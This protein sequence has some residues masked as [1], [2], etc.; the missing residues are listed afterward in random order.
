M[1]GV[2]LHVPF[3]RTLCPYCDFVKRPLE[4]AVPEAFV[5]AIEAEIQRFE[6]PNEIVSIFFGG[7]TPSLL[8]RDALKRIIDAIGRRFRNATGIDELEITLEANPDDV[9]LDLAEMW[10]D[11]GVNRVSLGV[12]SFNDEVL[13][14]LG[15]RHD[16]ECAKKACETVA[17]RFENW[18]MDFI[19]GARPLEPWPDTLRECR[20]FGSPH[21]STYALSYEDKTPFYKRRNDAIDDDAYVACVEAA[22][23]ALDHVSRYEI[24]NYAKPGYESR[25]NLIYWRNESYAGFG[26]G[27]Y[28]FIDGVRYRN[29]PSVHDYIEQPGLRVESLVLE[30]R[31]IRLETVIQHLRL[32]TGLSKSAYAKRFGSEVEADF[33]PELRQLASAGLIEVSPDAIEPSPKG[34]LLHNEIGLVLVG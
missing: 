1:I 29:T 33:G 14:Y 34:L 27:A 21:V 16:A 9:T 2:Y 15:R 19:F 20:A 24:S 31:E 6:G 23:G 17:E 13:A 22:N 28:G 7:G 30:E 11:V 3:C 32:T 26:P 4:G 25:H 18:S 12:Q 10:R 5:K 8:G